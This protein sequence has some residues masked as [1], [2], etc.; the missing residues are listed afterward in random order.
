MRFIALACITLIAACT[1]DKSAPA[2]SARITA[3][4][5]TPNPPPVA[6]PTAAGEWD[7]TFAGIGALRAGMSVDEASAALHNNLIVPSEMGDCTYGKLKNAPEGIALMFE[8][9]VFSRVDVRSGTVKT[10]EGAGIG[11]TEAK[12]DS[13]YDG[14]VKTTPAKYDNGHTLIVTPKD[15]SNNRI[16][17]ETDGKKVTRFRSGREPAVEY[18]EGCG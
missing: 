6:A 15:G 11:D 17:F 13:L 4:Q 9:A 12:I 3:N 7:V 10:V 5:P 8:K 16:V 2:D 18:V 1:T 14:Q